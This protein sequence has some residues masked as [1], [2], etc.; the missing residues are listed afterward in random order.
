M[1]PWDWSKR[2]RSLRGGLPRSHSLGRLE[3]E[4]TLGWSLQHRTSKRGR[5]TRATLRPRP[6]VCTRHSRQRPRRWALRP[7]PGR[8]RLADPGRWNAGVRYHAQHGCAARGTSCA[9]RTVR[10]PAPPPS[11]LLSTP[12][13]A[14]PTRH[15]ALRGSFGRVP[16]RP[17]TPTNLAHKRRSAGG[18]RS[19]SSISSRPPELTLAHRRRKHPNL[20][21]RRRHLPSPRRPLLPPS[22]PCSPL[23]CVQRQHKVRCPTLALANV[24]RC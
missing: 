7:R 4:L 10:V 21:H 17:S 20:T 3:W 12:Q 19:Y 23:G 14:P 6:A 9:A 13:W 2:R 18:G 15:H 5:Q 1:R 16:Q 22:G 24:V 8:P 11:P